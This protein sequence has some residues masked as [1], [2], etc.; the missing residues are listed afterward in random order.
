[1]LLSNPKIKDCAVIGVS[2]GKAGEL[3]KAFVVKGDPSLTEQEV[4]KYVQGNFL[5]HNF[6]TRKVSKILVSKI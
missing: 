1:M 2:D 5:V 6:S 4:I 3:P